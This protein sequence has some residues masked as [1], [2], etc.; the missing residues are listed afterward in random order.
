M[1]KFDVMSH[2]LVPKHVLLKP[3]EAQLILDKYNIRR[4]QLPKIFLKDP[5]AKS[6]G[7]HVGD[8]IRIDRDSFTAGSTTLY[9]L[10]ID[11]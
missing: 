2:K 1:A 11:I 7:A 3:E 9:R 5:C 6:L 4:E 8:I 10:V